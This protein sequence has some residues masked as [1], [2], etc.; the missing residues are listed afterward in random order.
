MLRTQNWTEITKNLQKVVL[1]MA[2]ANLCAFLWAQR[3]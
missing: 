1:Q 3:F 2:K